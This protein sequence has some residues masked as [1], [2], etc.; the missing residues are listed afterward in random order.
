MNQLGLATYIDW[1]APGQSINFQTAEK[2]RT[3]QL[4]YKRKN[5]YWYRENEGSESALTEQEIETEWT[6]LFGDAKGRFLTSPTCLSTAESPEGLT[7][8]DINQTLGR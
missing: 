5:T 8:A 7:P 4:L 1:N 6:T 2:L 3:R